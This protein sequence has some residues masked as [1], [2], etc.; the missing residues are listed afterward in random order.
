MNTQ[1]DNSYFH[2]SIS[3]EKLDRNFQKIDKVKSGKGP[4][5]T[6]AEL[7]NRDKP[8]SKSFLCQAIT[9]P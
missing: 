6:L 1:Q 2:S 5:K 9:Q 7:L 3:T 8:N 4:K